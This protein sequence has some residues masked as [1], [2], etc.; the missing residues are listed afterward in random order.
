MVVS[1][2]AGR[3]PA[4]DVPAAL[5][6][7]T[8]ALDP[9]PRAGSAPAAWRSPLGLV[10]GLFLSQSA[11]A[12]GFLASLAIAWWGFHAPEAVLALDPD[13]LTRAGALAAL[14]GTAAGNLGVLAL[15]FLLYRWRGAGAPAAGFAPLSAPRVA[16]LAGGMALVLLILSAL[17]EVGFAALT[18]REPHSNA[19]PL[20]AQLLA[21]GASPALAAGLVFTV[22]VLA[23]LAE[24]T[25]YR[26]L[27]YRAFRDRAGVPLAAVLSGLLFSLVHFEPD[28]VLVLWWIGMALAFLAERTG[29]LLPAM[30]THGLYNGLSL[31][32][33][34]VHR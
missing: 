4:V 34:L 2:V 10:A 30:A 24:E 26:G 8:L 28:H 17:H 5:A 15:A 27:I 6:L 25:V 12:I 11:V 32:I 20:L 23:P 9:L 3:R 14:G 31:V 7:P 29:S 1:A 18:G 22:V 33:Y 19:E 13:R 21:P 16:R